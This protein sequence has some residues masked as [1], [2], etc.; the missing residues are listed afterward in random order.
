MTHATE[1]VHTKKIALE[2]IYNG[3]TKDI[4]ASP[5]ETVRSVLEEAIRKFHVVN[6]PHVLAL[7][8]TDGSEVTP[9]TMSLAEANITNDTTLLLRPSAV[10]GGS[11]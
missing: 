10:K 6:Q 11:D 1:D 8:R 4:S 7:F 5:H 9:E 3:L 2:V